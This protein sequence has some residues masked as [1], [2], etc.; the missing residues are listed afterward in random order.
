[1]TLV[2]WKTPPGRVKLVE[3]IL[4]DAIEGPCLQN[5]LWRLEGQKELF[6]ELFWVFYLKEAR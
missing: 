5:R 6:S 3:S 4:D 1:L 2:V